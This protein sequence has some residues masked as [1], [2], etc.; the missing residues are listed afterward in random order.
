MSVEFFMINSAHQIARIR[1][2]KTDRMLILF[3]RADMNSEWSLRRA[4]GRPGPPVDQPPTDTLVR[5]IPVDTANTDSRWAAWSTGI[6]GRETIGDRITY[7]SYRV[8][9]TL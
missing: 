2:L 7:R 5:C 6:Q 9:L 1:T 8:Y 4:P 3:S